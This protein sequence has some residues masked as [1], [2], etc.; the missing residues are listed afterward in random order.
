VLSLSLKDSSVVLNILHYSVSYP[1]SECTVCAQA[2]SIAVIFWANTFT[3]RD[4]CFFIVDP[5]FSTPL[6]WL[7]RSPMACYIVSML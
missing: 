5:L 3:V 4:A 1:V 6:T 7:C 2:F